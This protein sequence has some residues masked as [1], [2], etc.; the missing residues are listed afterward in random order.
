LENVEEFQ[1]WGPARKGKPVKSRR[2]ETFRKWKEQL[3]VL[4]YEIEHRELVAADY[5]APTIRKRFFLIARCDGKKIIWPERTHAP[6]DSEEVKNGKCK[7]WRGAAEIIDWT[8]PCPSIFDTT[9]EIKEKYGIR[10]VRPLAVN[11]QK[12]IARGIEKFVL[13][14]KEPFI[15]P[16]G[17]MILK[18]L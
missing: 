9:D 3:Q 1:T 13:Q 11:T 7:P 8:I 15:V 16:I 17:C 14:N 12:R 4:G 6:K 2:G 18:N 10:A 5:G